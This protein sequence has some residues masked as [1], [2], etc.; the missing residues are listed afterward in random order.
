MKKLLAA[1]IALCMVFSLCT[2]SA[3]AVGG[4][5][6]DNPLQDVRVRQAL[7]YA[8]DMDAIVDALCYGIHTS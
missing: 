3:L 7:W 5:E 4:T 8:I 6:Y 1:L 2:V